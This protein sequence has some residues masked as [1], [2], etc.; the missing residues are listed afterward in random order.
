MEFSRQ[1]YWSELPFPSPEV[2]PNPGI[3]PWSPVSQVD[4]LPF[5]LQGSLRETVFPENCQS[6]SYPASSSDYV[7]LFRRNILQ[8]M[9]GTAPGQLEQHALVV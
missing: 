1:E 4:S 5:E 8:C 6:L 2:L 3:E 7:T 9:K